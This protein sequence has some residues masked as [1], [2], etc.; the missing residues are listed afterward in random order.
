[1]GCPSR[2]GELLKKMGQDVRIRW[3]VLTWGA[4]IFFPG[5]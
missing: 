2:S 4:V 5:L 1:M 3:A